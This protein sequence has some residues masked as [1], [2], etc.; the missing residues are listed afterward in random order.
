MNTNMKFKFR[1]FPANF[2]DRF[3]DGAY[4]VGRGADPRHPD[5]IA[6]SQHVPTTAGTAP[7]AQKHKSRRTRK[8]LRPA[9]E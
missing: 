9:A 2:G 4:T 1:D 5:E 6:A 3:P 7:K 8:S